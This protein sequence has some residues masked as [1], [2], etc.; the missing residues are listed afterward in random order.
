MKVDE[1]KKILEQKEKTQK[2]EIEA[3]QVIEQD[4]LKKIE[5]QKERERKELRQVRDDL[6]KRFPKKPQDVFVKC[7]GCKKELDMS[8]AEIITKGYVKLFRIQECKCGS[9]NVEYISSIG[10]RST[11]RFD[12][13]L[14]ELEK[15]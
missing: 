14:N 2:Q 4:R 13:L 5:E 6:A 3:H 11:S 1:A 10:A 15:S 8:K 12:S 7:W 9:F